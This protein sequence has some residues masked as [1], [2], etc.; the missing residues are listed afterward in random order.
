M[1][2][3]RIS[4]LVGTALLASC[5]GREPDPI[6]QAA[7]VADDA[8]TCPEDSTRV[9]EIGRGRYRLSGCNRVVVYTCDVSAGPPR[10][11]RK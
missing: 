2:G 1:D 11:E 4:V 8:W 3:R 6:V 5:K 9:F 7:S 10:C